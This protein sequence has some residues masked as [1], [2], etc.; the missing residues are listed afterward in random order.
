M[1]T[2]KLFYKVDV[3]PFTRSGNNY[4]IVVEEELGDGAYN[5][6][7]NWVT[8][9]SNQG[10]LNPNETDEI[11]YTVNVPKDANGGGQYF[12]ILVT[13][14]EDPNKA[15]GD[16]NV[17]LNEIIRIASTVYATISGKDMQLSGAIRENN[18]ASFFLVP[19]IKSSFVAE[20]T[21]NTH[22]EIDYYM[23]VFP[24]FS[25]EEVYTNEEDPKHVIVL[26]GTTRYI[27]QEWTETPQIGIFNVRQVVAYGSD[28]NE[29]S[30][31]EKMVIVCPAWLIFVVLFVIFALIFYFVA[32][33]KARKKAAKK[34]EKTA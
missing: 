32:K 31:T 25:S 33:A 13:R 10:S 11:T 27:E 17:S 3:V 30:I 14:T 5:D 29:K 2:E 9:S 6:I 21:G 23:Q 1:I 28:D 20:N 22:M 12:A 4:D 24:L 8:F 18:M 34:A 19:P 15:S 26:P 16:G 7:V